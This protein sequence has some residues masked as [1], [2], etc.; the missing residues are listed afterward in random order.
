[1]RLS[2]RQI[3][4]AHISMLMIE[5]TE[6]GLAASLHTVME[7]K[8]LNYILAHLEI[9]PLSMWTVRGQWVESIF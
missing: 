9:H 7:I 8:E 6:D 4:G 3:P 5:K 2:L 1:M